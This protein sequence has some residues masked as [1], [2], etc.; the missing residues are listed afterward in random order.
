MQVISDATN[1]IQEKREMSF[2]TQSNVGMRR[3]KASSKN[4]ANLFLQK[5]RGLLQGLETASVNVG[6]YTKIHYSFP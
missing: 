4:R 2:K 5:R 1:T 3:G 6:V